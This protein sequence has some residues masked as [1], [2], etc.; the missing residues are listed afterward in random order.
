MPRSASTNR[1]KRAPLGFHS[2][3]CNGASPTYGSSNSNLGISGSSPFTISVLASTFL[4]SG[5]Q[6][7]MAIGNASGTNTGLVI[8]S[9][10]NTWQVLINGTGI[11]PLAV[12]FIKTNVPDEITVTYAGG[13]AP[14]LVYANG[15][16]INGS[17]S[18]TMALVDAPVRWGRDNAS[19]N[20]L[21]G[22][23]SSVRA[24]NVSLTA[25]QVAD[26][27]RTK[28]VPTTG[29]VRWYKLNEGT[30]ST[31]YDS[32]PTADQGTITNPYWSFNNVPF[33]LPVCAS[34]NP[35]QLPNCLFYYEADQGVTLDV[36]NKVSQWD[37]LSGNGSHMTQ[38]TAG[39]RFTYTASSIN[40]LPTVNLVAGTG[41]VMTAT[42][43]YFANQPH[44]LV[45]V[46]RAY[47]TQPSAYSGI[48]SI[49]S[50]AVGGYTSC[51]GTDNSTNIW[52]GGAGD[53]TPT[54]TPPVS[55]TVYF[56]VKTTDNRYTSSFI[57]NVSK[58]TAKQLV[59][60]TVNPLSTVAIG[61]YTAGSN[62]GNWNVALIAG[63][64]KELLPSEMNALATY[65]NDKY[66]MGMTV[67]AR[68]SASNRILIS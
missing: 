48:I 20:P 9:S 45:V 55:N 14:I 53:G 33:C 42:S 30:G 19:A 22:T 7:T 37:D 68:V 51:I 16:I 1:V 3:M 60:Y 50:G 57:N 58:G 62:S 35:A 21:T 23:V 41:N 28:E 36:S 5:T 34:A 2:L 56:F 64:N 26:M 46:A 43:N 44:T 12:P 32:S 6:A 54:F 17:G 67:G 49:G 24:W 65:V 39:L 8:R 31:A 27:Y 10:S 52:F 15:T 11:L 47:S 25:N 4:L 38:A 63:F 40:G 61:Q 59:T 66:A 29:L 13:S 18:L